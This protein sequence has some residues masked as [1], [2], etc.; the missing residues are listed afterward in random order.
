MNDVQRELTRKEWSAIKKLVE[1]SCANYCREH[2][3]LKLND[4]CYMFGKCCTGSYCKYFKAAVLPLDPAL[5][6]ALIGGGDTQPCA[7][8][9]KC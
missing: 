9:G 7:N 5:E 8:C 3:C 2:G 6:V 1:S 4:T